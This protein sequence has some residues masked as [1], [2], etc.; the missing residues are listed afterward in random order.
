MTVDEVKRRVAEIEA[1]AF[2]D[3]A[4]HS[5]EDKL[6]ADVLRAIAAGDCAD[7]AAIAQAVL[8]TSKIDFAR[9]CD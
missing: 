6:R 1:L 9:W 3:E 7:P 8:E 2:D 4:A 5:E